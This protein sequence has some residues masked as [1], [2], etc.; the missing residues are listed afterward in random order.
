MTLSLAV[1]AGLGAV[2][3]WA[4]T[5]AGD[6]AVTDPAVLGAMWFGRPRTLLV[7]LPPLLHFGAGM[8]V[9]FLGRLVPDVST[10]TTALAAVSVNGAATLLE[11]AYGAGVMGV[12]WWLLGS[13]ISAALMLLGAG[14][15]RRATR[16]LARA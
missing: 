9:G 2:L 11:N 7:L 14:L 3:V 4:P 15:A 8:G 10:T 12:G 5:I 1:G 6:T 13:L 16:R